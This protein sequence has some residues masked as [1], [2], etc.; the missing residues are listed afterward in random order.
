MKGIEYS[1]LKIIMNTRSNLSPPAI[2]WKFT[3][4]MEKSFPVRAVP[5]QVISCMSLGQFDSN[6]LVAAIV[7]NDL[8]ELTF[9][10][11]MDSTLA[12]VTMADA[13]GARIY[14]RSL[15]FLLETAFSALFPQAV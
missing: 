5:L 10:I 11:K 4:R 12:P 15:T 9:P 3:S 14:R 1:L 13:D 2:T 6:P 8:R 7:N